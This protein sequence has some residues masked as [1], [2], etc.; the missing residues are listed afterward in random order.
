MVESSWIGLGYPLQAQE[1]LEDVKMMH[2]EHLV[3]PDCVPVVQP[4]GQVT[5]AAQAHE[6]GAQAA[7]GSEDRGGYPEV[8]VWKEEHSD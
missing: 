6:C 4:S 8:G 5:S 7:G 2:T 1:H 3:P